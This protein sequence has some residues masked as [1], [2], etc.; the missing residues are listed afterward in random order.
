MNTMYRESDIESMEFMGD[1]KG[2]STKTFEDWI[3][4]TV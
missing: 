1:G 3:P 4:L 2:R